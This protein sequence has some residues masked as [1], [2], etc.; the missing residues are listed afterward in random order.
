VF[1]LPVMKKTI[2]ALALSA[3]VWAAPPKTNLPNP[4]SY[5][6][7]TCVSFAV[8]QAR[9]GDAA[10]DQALRSI[11]GD[12]EKRNLQPGSWIAILSGLLSSSQKQQFL[13]GL[14]PFQGVRLDYIDPKGV[15]HSTTVISIAGWRGLQS[16]YW[17]KLQMDESGKPWPLK[18]YG[19]A[20]VAV[21]GKSAVARMDGNFYAFTDA[22]QVERSFT[23]P[24]SA[25]TALYK[26]LNQ[27]RD[28]YG[29]LFNK[30][31]SIRR[32]LFWVDQFDLGAVEQAMG[33]EK[34]A[35]ALDSIEYLSWEGEFLDED[36]CALE[37]RWKTSNPDLV[38]E[39]LS[40]ARKVLK[41]RGRPATMQTVGL[42]DEI[43]LNMEL[44]GNRRFF[45]DY[46]AK[47][48]PI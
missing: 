25:P 14:L 45:V 31:Q 33:V 43:L 17:S 18:R 9:P 15:P 48:E 21:R 13:L 23:R 2:L 19:K 40:V 39:M 47:K 3:S 29:L 10:F 5:V 4:L 37:M 28:T 1:E 34:F 16:I 41:E 46:L 8:L 32:F 22:S 38:E 12:L 20:D 26:G 44:G 30:Q 7:P 36:R 35:K 24:P 11:W 6:D 42:E 27:Q